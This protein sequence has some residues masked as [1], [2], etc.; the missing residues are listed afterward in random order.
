MKPSN[1]KNTEIS[2]RQKNQM[3]AVC[4]L[5]CSGCDILQATNDPKIAQGIVDWFKK[6]R[7][8]EVKIEDIHCSGCKG[9]RAKHWSLDCWILKCCVDKKGFEFCCECQD[10]PCERLDEWAKSSKRY[11]EALNR[12]KK[13][14]KKF[15]S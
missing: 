7:N 13:M 5:V 1:N 8:E 15:E 3:I 4:G 9:G 10:F 12:L 11:G 2:T 6:E 14:G